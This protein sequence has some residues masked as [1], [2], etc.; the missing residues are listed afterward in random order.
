MK[1]Y[2]FVEIPQA[3]L[4]QSLLTEATYL[5]PSKALEKE[6]ILFKSITSNGTSSYAINGFEGYMT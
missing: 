4:R 1:T 2:R 3:L 6:E 5:A